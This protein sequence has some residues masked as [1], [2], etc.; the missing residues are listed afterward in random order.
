MLG[1]IAIT[2]LCFI[3]AAAAAY[4]LVKWLFKKDEQIED[5][6]RAAGKLAVELSKVGMV[7]LPEFL[8]DYSVGDYSEMLRKMK[9]T[10][11]LA[12]GDPVAF[13]REFDAVYNRVLEAKLKTEEGRIL[14]AAKLQDASVSTD[15]KAVAQAPKAV[16]EKS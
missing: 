1:A 12:T 6:R 3:G 2:L 5:R 11:E 13:M 10:A 15:S 16:V 8:I 4:F 14:L 7:K 9:N